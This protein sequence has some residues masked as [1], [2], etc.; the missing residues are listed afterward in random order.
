MCCVV[1]IPYNIVV[2]VSA[3][4]FQVFCRG[5]YMLHLI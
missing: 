2:V 3:S 4:E 5:K 1:I